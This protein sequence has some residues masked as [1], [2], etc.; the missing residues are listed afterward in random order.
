MNVRRLLASACSV[1]ALLA[2]TGCSK[3]EKP[4]PIV[5]LVNEGRSTYAEAG[6]WCFEEGQTG[7]ECATR[8]EGSTVFRVQAGT[9][10]VDVDKE[11]VDSGWVVTLSDEARPS[12]QPFVSEVQ[13]GNHYYSLPIPDLRQDSTLRLT[14]RALTDGDEPV[15][16]TWDFALRPR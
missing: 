3:P 10:G 8:E 15:R 13:R 14:V 7:D 16:G 4:A 5:T 11:L 12:E 9:L 6:T 1:G 2:L